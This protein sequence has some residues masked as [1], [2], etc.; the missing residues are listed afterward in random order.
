MLASRPWSPF[1]SP[2]PFSITAEDVAVVEDALAIRPGDRVLC[3]GSAGDTA[4]SVL[5]RDPARVDA[6]DLS[7][8]QLCEIGL[9]AEAIRQLSLERVRILLGV[10]R[11]GRRALALYAQLRPGLSPPMRAFWDQHRWMIVRGLIWQGGVMRMIRFAR[12][13]LSLLIG[14]KWLDEMASLSTPEAAADFVA[15]LRHDWRVGAVLAVLSNRFALGAFYPDTGLRHL[16][17]K[18]AVREYMVERLQT[19][20]TNRPPGRHPLLHPLLFERYPTTDALPLYLRPAEYA[21]VQARIA[22]LHLAHADLRTYIGALPPD[23]IA[24]FA[25]L[26][27]MDWL[28]DD[29][30]GD[31]LGEIARAGAPGARV[32]MYSRSRPLVMPTSADAPVVLDQ[33]HSA[34]LAARDGIG[35]YRYTYLLRVEKPAPVRV[36]V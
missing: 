30:V 31:L 21:G 23:A 26:N 34:R 27:V 12:K 3:L 9:K 22:R 2:I 13:A 11:D 28:D 10:D 20:L 14:P 32:L 1:Y 35:Y 7:F 19:M 24:G 5:A 16:R 4:I 29:R 8:P 6:V 18:P 15:R 36:A 17:G 33:A 25:L